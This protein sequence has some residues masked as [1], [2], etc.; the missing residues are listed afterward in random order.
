MVALKLLESVLG[1]VAT[2]GMAGY[3]FGWLCFIACVICTLAKLHSGAMWPVIA[4]FFSEA[5]R[6]SLPLA[7]LGLAVIGHIQ[8]K[9]YVKEAKH[10]LN[11]K[12]VQKQYATQENSIRR[13]CHDGIRSDVYRL[14]I[15][16]DSEPES[17]F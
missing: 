14:C 12:T 3:L 15:S 10:C 8:H 4:R 13:S 9:R 1:K 5:V 6:C 2:I 17:G 11:N 16:G 7:F